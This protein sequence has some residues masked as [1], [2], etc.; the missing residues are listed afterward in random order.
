MP[1][2]WYEKYQSSEALVD[3]QWDLYP[4]TCLT[5]SSKRVVAVAVVASGCLEPRIA[6]ELLIWHRVGGDLVQPRGEA[7]GQQVLALQ[8]HPQTPRHRQTHP[9]TADKVWMKVHHQGKAA[10]VR[11]RDGKVGAWPWRCLH[12][13]HLPVLAPRGSSSA[14]PGRPDMNSISSSST[15]TSG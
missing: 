12:T 1:L 2:P 11:G 9:N 5:P 7:D 6:A 3:P 4:S 13:Y 10:W 8:D 15:R 14:A